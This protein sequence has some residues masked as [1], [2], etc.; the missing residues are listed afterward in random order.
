MLEYVLA[1][2]ALLGLVVVMGYLVQA[3]RSS[4]DRAQTLVRSDC[5]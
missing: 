4:A 5:P 3:A 1:T 2:V